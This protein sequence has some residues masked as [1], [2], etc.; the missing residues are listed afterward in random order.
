MAVKV[1]MVVTLD[2][3]EVMGGENFRRGSGTQREGRPRR[4]PEEGGVRWAVILG[5]AWR[6]FVEGPFSLAIVLFSP[7]TV[8]HSST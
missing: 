1:L 3:R 7:L 5:D 4:P 8:L 2:L 6:T